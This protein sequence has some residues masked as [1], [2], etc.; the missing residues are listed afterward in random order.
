[1]ITEDKIKIFKRYDGDIDSWARS[2]SK[3]EKFIMTD[4]DWYIIDALIQDLLLVKKGL[5]SLEFT[6]TLNSKL[7]ENCDSEKTINQLQKLADKK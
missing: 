3:R 6:N 1:M 5:T 2:G 7:K 4:N